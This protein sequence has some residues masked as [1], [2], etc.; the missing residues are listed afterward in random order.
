MKTVYIG[1][2]LA[3]KAGWAVL[4]AS[5]KR[6]DSG[7]WDCSILKGEGY[8]MRYLR[9]KLYLKALLREHLDPVVFYEQSVNQAG[10]AS[11]KVQDGLLG[12]ALCLLESVGVSQYAPIHYATA[13]KHATGNGAASKGDMI[14]AAAV[15]WA[16]CPKDDN[17]A[18]ALWIADCGRATLEDERC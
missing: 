14:E 4:D 18:D 6:I 13:K 9:L 8:G 2:D 7:V 17:E 1:L 11:G 16:Y 12:V 15:R 5:G 10:P 3:T